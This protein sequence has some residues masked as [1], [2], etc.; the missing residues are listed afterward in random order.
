MSQSTEASCWRLERATHW[1]VKRST[2]IIPAN[3]VGSTLASWHS[4]KNGVSKCNRA[5]FISMFYFEAKNRLHK[6]LKHTSL[7]P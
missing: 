6:A 2:N 4:E 7:H 5:T 1:P 3:A